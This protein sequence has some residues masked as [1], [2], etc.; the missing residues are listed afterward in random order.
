MATSL[1]LS[2]LPH[3]YYTLLTAAS[4]SGPSKGEL[5]SEVVSVGEAMLVS[6]VACERA[7]SKKWLARSRSTCTHHVS[8]RK[9]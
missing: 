4:W 8:A 3:Y 5:K 2:Q 7:E 9:Q 6:W 1:S